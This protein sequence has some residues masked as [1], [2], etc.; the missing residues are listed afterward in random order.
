MSRFYWHSE[1]FL[2]FCHN[3]VGVSFWI[4][5][6]N[7]FQFFESV[8]FG[9]FFR[10]FY[11]S[12]LVTHF[13]NDE[14]YIRNFYIQVKRKQNFFGFRSEFLSNFYQS[15]F[16]NF[17]IGFFQHFFNFCSETLDNISVSNFEKIHISCGFITRHSENIYIIYI[18]IDNRISCLV[19]F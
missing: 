15:F 1:Q 8:F 16:Q 13:W 4:Y 3:S 11:N 5:N 10:K 7:L 2:H 17:F 12:F 18:R 19:I 14:F 9:V 6:L